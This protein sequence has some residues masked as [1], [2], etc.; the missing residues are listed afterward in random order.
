VTVEPGNVDEVI[1][2]VRYASHIRLS[3]R[4]LR[5]AVRLVPGRSKLAG[6]LSRY[7]AISSGDVFTT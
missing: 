6:G 4:V 3:Q 5:L 7:G 2:A 1:E